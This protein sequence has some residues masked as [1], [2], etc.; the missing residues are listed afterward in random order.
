M[1]LSKLAEVFSGVEITRANLDPTAG[2][3]YRLIQCHDLM[4]L[5]FGEFANDRRSQLPLRTHH[6]DPHQAAREVWFTVNAL[7]RASSNTPSQRATTTVAMQLP[8][9]FTAVRPMSMI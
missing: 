5:P 7:M 2:E 6:C 3:P 4:G 1:K 9:T 8:M